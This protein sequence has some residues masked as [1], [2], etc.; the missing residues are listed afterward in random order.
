MTNGLAARWLRAWIA[1]GQDSLAGAALAAQQ[2]GCLAGRG[3]EGH[4]QGLTHLRLARLE[5]HLGHDRA[6]LLLQLVHLGLQPPHVGDPVEDHAK[7]IRR[8]RLGQVIEG[9]TPHG[10]DRRFDGGIGRDDHHVESGRQAEQTR[11]EVQTL[12][13]SQP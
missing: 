1:P 3:L 7:L 6:D 5:V 11:Q 13:L 12:F 4:V 9:P 8:K 2:D 10:L